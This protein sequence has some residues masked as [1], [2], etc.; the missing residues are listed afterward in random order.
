MNRINLKF[1]QKFGGHW[2]KA[3]FYKKKP[4][5]KEVKRI[6]GVRFCEAVKKAITYPIL[7]D[8]K[9]ISCEGAQY[10]LGWKSKYKNELLNDCRDKNQ[11]EIKVLQSLLSNIPHFRKPFKYIG[12]NTEGEADLIISFSTPEKIKELVKIYN[13]RDGDNLD[14]SLNSM[15]PICGGIAVKSYL[16]KK[17]SLSFGCDDSRKFSG[18]GRDTL[19]I[20]IPNN[21]FKVFVD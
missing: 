11:T 18:L 6:E 16:E 20:G 19:T 2:I 9:S 13:Y 21:L 15:M 1:S 3:K 12:L 7:L 17:I 8:R 4:N 10:A 14:V 5:L